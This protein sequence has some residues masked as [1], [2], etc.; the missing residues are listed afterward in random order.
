MTKHFAL[1]LSALVLG[2]S[3]SYA[4]SVSFQSMRMDRDAASGGLA[5]ASVA[6]VSNVAMS[7][8]KNAAAV[9]FYDGKG[10]SMISFSMSSPKAG[11]T[12][13]I[14]AGAGIKLGKRCALSLAFDYH[15][16]F[17]YQI[18]DD[19]GIPGNEFKTSAKFAALGFGYKVTD[20][21]SLGVNAKFASETLSSQGGP[22]VLAT[23]VFAMFKKGGLSAAI[24]AS[25]IGGGAKDVSGNSYST[26][27]SVTA[28]IA[29]LLGQKTAGAFE[30]CG[31]FDYFLNGGVS[32]AAGVRYSYKEIVTARA[33]YHF[34][35][36]K[37]PL[38]SYLALGL[39]IKFFGVHL[40]FTY[41]LANEVLGGSLCAGLGYSF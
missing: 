2:V 11:S 14:T 31:D 19:F 32:A 5:G 25:S 27:A 8:F 22:R 6:S 3:M 1:C 26:P 21:L 7:A 13:D 16:G 41:H 23:D 28:G 35:S 40:D 39:G 29:Y 12:S 33:G 34:G 15:N 18:V 30:I 10:D 4:Q 24:G 38:P 36:D 20:W 9:P 17:K 37:S